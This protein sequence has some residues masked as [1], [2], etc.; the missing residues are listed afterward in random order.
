MV[1]L[2][3]PTHVG[4]CLRTTHSYVTYFYDYCFIFFLL[5]YLLLYFV[6]FIL[7]CFTYNCCCCCFYFI[8][9]F[10]HCFNW[11]QNN[12][13]SLWLE[14][15]HFHEKIQ[16][17]KAVFSLFSS[18]FI[19]R[20]LLQSR[21][22]TPCLGSCKFALPKT[23]AYKYRILLILCFKTH[24]IYWGIELLTWQTYFHVLRKSR[25]YPS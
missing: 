8:L 13:K 6:Y 12:R 18:L 3:L 1:T 20:L 15:S 14:T 10:Q 16:F 9:L 7:L 5:F 24:Q 25:K 2:P 17:H 22:S 19:I 4:F 11:I 23:S 21:D